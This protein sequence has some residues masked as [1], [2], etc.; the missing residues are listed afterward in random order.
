MSVETVL[1]LIN[2][3]SN[4]VNICNIILVFG[5]ASLIV[6]SGIFFSVISDGYSDEGVVSKCKLIF[7][8]CLIVLLSLA[9]VRAV[10]PDEKTMYMISGVHYLKQTDIPTK[11]ATLI[12]LKLDEFSHVKKAT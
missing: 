6:V 12:N 7:K 2:V 9:V 5:S 1:Y 3:G 10:L 11:V 4:L 8:K